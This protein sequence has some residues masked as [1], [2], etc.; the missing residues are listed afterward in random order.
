MNLRAGSG[1]WGVPMATDIA[2]AIGAVALLGPKVPSSLKLFLLSLAI[3]D[4]LG[5]ILVIAVF[6]TDS[7]RFEALGVAAGLIGLIALLRTAGVVWIAAYAA[8]GTGVWLAVFQSGVHPTV[9][10]AVLGL[11]APARSLAPAAT[12]RGGAPISPTTPSRQSCGP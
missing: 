10:G 3:V 6:Y 8:L 5:A 4:D 11:M 1:G 12:A 9:S 2:F 7:I